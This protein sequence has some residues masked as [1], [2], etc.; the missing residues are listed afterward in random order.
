MVVTIWPV[1]WKFLK[2][3]LSIFVFYGILKIDTAGDN[4]TV[5]PRKSFRRIRPY[6]MPILRHP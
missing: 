2:K 5:H 6:E 3:S 1:F 4:G